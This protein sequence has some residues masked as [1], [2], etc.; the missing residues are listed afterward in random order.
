LDAELPEEIFSLVN[1]TTLSIHVCSLR[2]TISPRFTNLAKLT[3]LD[4]SNNQLSG[5]VP[6]VV[7]QMPS[8]Q[9]LEVSYNRE[10]RGVLTLPVGSNLRVYTAG[11]NIALT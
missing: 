1:L 8:L 9:K 7:V 3:I 6:D 2:G 11:T 4:L 5:T 10:L